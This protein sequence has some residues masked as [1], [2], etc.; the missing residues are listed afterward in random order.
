MTLNVD[1]LRKLL[2]SKGLSLRPCAMDC[3]SAKLI[4]QAGF[5]IIG[6]SGY[7]VSAVYIGQPDLELLGFEGMYDQVK[8]IIDTV[9]DTPVDVDGDNGYGNATKTYYVV[10]KYI[11]AGAAGIRIEDQAPMKRCGHMDGKEIIPMFEMEDKIRAAIQARDHTGDIVI[12]IRTD[13]MSV[14]GPEKTIRRI[15]AYSKYDIDY[16]YVE[17][18]QT[19]REIEMLVDAIYPMPLAMNIIPGGKTPDFTLEDLEIAGVRYLS[20][21]MICLYPAVKAIQEALQN[22]TIGN[23][24]YVEYSGVKWDEFN[25]IVAE[26]WQA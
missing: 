25:R 13:A 26:P 14:E 12:G 5:P 18:P 7:A 1:K 19:L 16:I 9:P 11:K 3:L 24:K 20:V 23:L 21:P 10:S 8:R 2:T 17:I 4:E 22:L 15:E 6:T